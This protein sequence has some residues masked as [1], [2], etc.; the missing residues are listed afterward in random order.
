M[1][2][3]DA[4]SKSFHSWATAEG[5]K[6]KLKDSKLVLKETNESYKLVIN[7]SIAIR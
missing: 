1:H 6:M 3:D 4:N 5:K 2:S 7:T